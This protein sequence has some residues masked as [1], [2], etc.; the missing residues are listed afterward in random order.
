[1]DWPYH[2]PHDHNDACGLCNGWSVG[3]RFISRQLDLLKGIMMATQDD[4]DTL[5]TSLDGVAAEL[6]TVDSEVEAL[7]AANAAAGSPLD[8]TG[9]Q[10]SFG[11]LKAAADKLATDAAPVV[12]VPAVPEDGSTPAA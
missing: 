10:T 3:E 11:N 1:M 2:Q 8:L 4:L 12:T 6:G 7:V 9:V 5:A